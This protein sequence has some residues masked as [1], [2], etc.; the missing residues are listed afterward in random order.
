LSFSTLDRHLKKRRW[1][2][3]R[4]R[5]PVDGQ[6]VP[7]ELATRKPPIIG[8]LAGLAVVLLAVRGGF[9]LGYFLAVQRPELPTVLEFDGRPVLAGREVLPCWT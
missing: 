1:K 6:L 9:L 8:T 3:K 2:R 7:V 4:R 5:A